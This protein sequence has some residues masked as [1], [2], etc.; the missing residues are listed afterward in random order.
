MSVRSRFQQA[1]VLG[2]VSAVLSFTAVSTGAA[3][4][5]VAVGGGVVT[6]TFEER[7]SLSLTPWLALRGELTDSWAVFT[8]VG[9]EHH[10]VPVPTIVCLGPGCPTSADNE[11][12]VTNVPASL[13]VRLSSRTAFLEIAS[14]IAWTRDEDD[15]ELGYGDGR[16]VRILR[17]S[18]HV[19]AEV[20]LGAGFHHTLSGALGAEWGLRYA[21][22]GAPRATE[23][24]RYLGI[25]RD[26]MAI[27]S[28]VAALTLAP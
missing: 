26:G 14:S 27:W 1:G 8:R 3:G 4:P 10:S 11:Q 21:Y 28:F 23:A 7:Q 18:N 24:T 16:K 13:G 19:L 20:G 2:M 22:R 12:R 5:V 9:Y 6:H 17:S 15:V 25:G